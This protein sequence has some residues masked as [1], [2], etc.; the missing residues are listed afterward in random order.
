MNLLKVTQFVIEMSYKAWISKVKSIIF[1]MMKSPQTAV[2]VYSST[3]LV[4]LFG[5]AFTADSP[6]WLVGLVCDE[7]LKKQTKRHKKTEK[8]NNR[9]N[10][11]GPSICIWPR[12]YPDSPTWLVAFGF[13]AVENDTT[14]MN[15]TLN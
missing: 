5:L 2:L 9:E 10:L 1:S 7:Q 4:S 15:P 12:F 13:I 3:S 6:T 11:C 8:Y 14:G